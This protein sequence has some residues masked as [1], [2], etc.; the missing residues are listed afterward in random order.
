MKRIWTTI[1]PILQSMTGCQILW[2]DAIWMSAGDIAVKRNGRP[3]Q[4]IADQFRTSITCEHILQ[5]AM[6]ADAGHESLR[7]TRFHDEAEYDVSEISNVLQDF[8]HRLDYL[9]VQGNVLGGEGRLKCRVF[10]C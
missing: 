10:C 6:I 8:V 1:A 9:F 7:V 4:K 5:L 2:F 3:P